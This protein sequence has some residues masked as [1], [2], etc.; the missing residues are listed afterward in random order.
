MYVN[1]WTCI[2]GRILWQSDSG[3]QQ[4]SRKP[5]CS[6]EMSH[7]VVLPTHV[8]TCTHT[9]TYTHTLRTW[10]WHL[11]THTHTHTQ[12][13]SSTYLTFHLPLSPLLLG[14]AAWGILTTT[15]VRAASFLGAL[16]RATSST[17]QWWSTAHRWE[18][19]THTHTLIH[20]HTHCSAAHLISL[21]HTLTHSAHPFNERVSVRLPPI[22]SFIKIFL[23]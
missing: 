18:S 11:Y 2:C 1:V 12:L 10:K 17:T 6:L 15:C 21:F 7:L 9:H 20:R 13:P 3:N 16:P 14:I 8:V 23:S 22:P 4:L 19:H 5:P